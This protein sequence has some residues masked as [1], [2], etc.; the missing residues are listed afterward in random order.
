MKAAEKPYLN[1]D[2]FLVFSLMPTR[3]WSRQERDVAKVRAF[4]QQ[5]RRTDGPK[6]SPDRREV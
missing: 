4:K 3:R 2:E 5:Q 1:R 6:L